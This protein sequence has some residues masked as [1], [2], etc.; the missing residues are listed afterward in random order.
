MTDIHF[1]RGD[2]NA[3]SDNGEINRAVYGISAAV[4]ENGGIIARF[5]RPGVAVIA[6]AL[7]RRE[8]SVATAYVIAVFVFIGIILR[9]NRRPAYG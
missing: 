6:A 8:G 3:C 5:K 4:I 1:L 7:T 9:I 2:R